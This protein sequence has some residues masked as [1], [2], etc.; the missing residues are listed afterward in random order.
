MESVERTLM[1]RTVSIG[2]NVAFRSI[3]WQT[4]KDTF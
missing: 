4:E 3:R 1:F 2:M